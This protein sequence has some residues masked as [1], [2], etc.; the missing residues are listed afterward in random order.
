MSNGDWMYTH[1]A[2]AML[3][4]LY[5][6]IYRNQRNYDKGRISASEALKAARRLRALTEAWTQRIGQSTLVV[7]RNPNHPVPKESDPTIAVGNTYPYG[8]TFERGHI[9]PLE[10]AASIVLEAFRLRASGMGCY[11]ISKRL[12]D[13]APPLARKN[14]PDR[15]I[16]FDPDFVAR[17]FPKHVYVDAGLVDEATWQKAQHSDRRAPAKPRKY[18]WPLT[19]AL[20]CECGYALSGM[21]SK[22]REKRYFWYV[23]RDRQ[24]AHGG[25][26][27]FDKNDIEAQF[28]ASLK[29]LR[30]V[31]SI[32][33][34]TH[35]RPSDDAD[36]RKSLMKQLTQARQELSHIPAI[37]ERVWA[38][39]DAG[40]LP[41][42]MVQARVATLE[43]KQKETASAVSRMEA[44]LTALNARQAGAENAAR[45]VE[46]A[47][48][49]WTRAPIE[50]QKAL[51]KRIADILGGGL[52]VTLDE[53]LEA[54]L[55]NRIVMARMATR[56]K[57]RRS[58]QGS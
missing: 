44:D 24:N 26:K 10:P 25:L 4:L 36:R 35:Q 39:F 50:E 21:T 31:P 56:A 48:E 15:P 53:T 40:Q 16:K 47:H 51:A 5:E 43:A 12:R 37:I 1:N 42:D 6:R 22:P 34:L 57:A 23:C 45:I 3:D 18:D 13:Q 19:G 58:N 14:H 2:V 7:D 32:A 54:E 38:A 27:A 17:I 11:S 20:K 33:E 9:V 28:I 55:I 46:A 29:L 41:A 49:R 8:L 30:S 52:I